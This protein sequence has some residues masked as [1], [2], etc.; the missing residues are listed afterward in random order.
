[1]IEQITTKELSMEKIEKETSLPNTPKFI[2]NM[3]NFETS[4]RYEG[5]VVKKENLGKSIA[6]LKLKYAR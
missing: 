5:L 1:M 4:S 6:E 3:Q 2:P